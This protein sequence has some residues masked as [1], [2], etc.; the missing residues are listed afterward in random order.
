MRMKSMMTIIQPYR[1]HCRDSVDTY[2][3]Q[4]LSRSR[5]LGR[6]SRHSIFNDII[7]R[8]IAIAHVPSVLEPIGLARS[9]GKRP[10]CLTLIPR[11]LRR[12]FV[13]DQRVSI[14]KLHHIP[15]PPQCD[16]NGGCGLRLLPVLR[17][18][19]SVKMV[20][21]IAVSFLCLLDFGTVE[22][23]GASSF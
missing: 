12:L 10:D 20:D 17:R 4:G 22:N 1:C 7:R 3:H 16:V 5:M 9:D 15:R 2:G 14:S 19:R 18:P 8:S 13:W 21:L 6:F 11:W 23:R